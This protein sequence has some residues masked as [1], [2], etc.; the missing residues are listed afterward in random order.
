MWKTGAGVGAAFLK[1]RNSCVSAYQDTYAS[2]NPI[3]KSPSYASWQLVGRRQ[4]LATVGV[5]QWSDSQCKLLLKM[6]Y[7]T[8]LQR[9]HCAL[10]LADQV[11]CGAN[12]VRLCTTYRKVIAEV[13]CLRQQMAECARTLPRLFSHIHVNLV[14]T[15]VLKTWHE[16]TGAN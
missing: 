10:A 3:S 7:T 12:H 5:V 13:A 8:V 15:A 16:Q 1:Q 14:R 2:V 6:T 9:A 11:P 4:C